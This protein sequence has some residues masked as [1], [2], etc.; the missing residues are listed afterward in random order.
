[1]YDLAKDPGE[2]NDLAAGHPE[3]VRSLQ[4]FLAEWEKEIGR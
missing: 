1:L 4:R 3:I 2:R